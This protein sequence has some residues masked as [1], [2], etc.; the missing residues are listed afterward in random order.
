MFNSGQL[1]IQPVP[2]RWWTCERQCLREARLSLST[3]CVWHVHF[4]EGLGENAGSLCSDIFRFRDPSCPELAS[5]GERVAPDRGDS[6]AGVMLNH[7]SG[8]ERLLWLPREEKGVKISNQSYDISA[9]KCIRNNDLWLSSAA[10]P[11]GAGP[12]SNRL[13][14]SASPS[15]M[16]LFGLLISGLTDQIAWAAVRVSSETLRAV[17]PILSPTEA[18][19]ELD[20]EFFTWG[21]KH[22]RSSALLWPDDGLA[23]GSELSIVGGPLRPLHLWVNAEK[24]LQGAKVQS[25][26]I[27]AKTQV[28]EMTEEK[29]LGTFLHSVGMSSSGRYGRLAY[30]FR[31]ANA[32]TNN[33]C[34]MTSSF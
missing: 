29:A 25:L 22:Q 26:K 24:R 34:K 23:S 9:E 8:L 7:C 30:L 3:G 5:Q 2:V 13:I 4:A 1:I 14:P 11:R 17:V 33:S 21:R 31:N 18:A 20:G 27:N 15:L 19:R 28:N 32:A 10:D 16:N 12:W 6:A